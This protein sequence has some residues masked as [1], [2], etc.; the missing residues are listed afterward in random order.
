MRIS[1]VP[2]TALALLALSAAGAAPQI[3]SS[4]ANPLVGATSADLG[5]TGDSGAS[6]STGVTAPAGFCD[7]TGASGVTGATGSTCTT[8][9]T[10]STGVTGATGVTG[11]TGVA[12]ATG[13]TGVTGASAAISATGTTGST[14]TAGAGVPVVTA[15]T[16]QPIS[17]AALL[18]G[19][20]GTGRK[21]RKNAPAPSLFA[22][23]NPLAG[24]LPGSVF[25]PFVSAAI[26]SEVPQFFVENF[27]VPPFLLPIYQSAGAAY[28]VPWQVLAAINQV[29]TNYGQDLNVSS[30]GAEGWMQFLPSTWKGYGV[31]ATGSGSAD[32]YNAAD[33][34]FAAA[35]YLA[36][37]GASQ[38]LP[39]AIY[40]YNHSTA[41]VQSVLLR[42]E[43]LSGVP[44][45]LVSS[46]TELADGHF[47]IQLRYH[48]TYRPIEQTDPAQTGATS[49]SVARK[50][51][52]P[53]PS[54]V[55]AGVSGAKSRR[56]P[57]AEIFADSDAAVVAVQDGTIIGIG[58]DARLGRYIQLEDN[59]GNVYTYGGLASISQ[60]YPTPK[61]SQVGETAAVSAPTGL[62]TAPAPT[63]PATAGVQLNGVGESALAAATTGA[64]P[65][66]TGQPASSAPA[67]ATAPAPPAAP[68]L[69]VDLRAVL[70]ASTVSSAA[71]AALSASLESALVNRYYTPAFGLHRNQLDV[72]RL[73]VGSRVLAGTM[74]GR[75]GQ[76]R[77][78]R[79]PHL[80]FEIRPAGNDE[81][82]IDPQSFLD[83]WTQLETLELHRA[84]FTQPLF[85]P[86]VHA[87][88]AGGTLL[89]S[90][91]DLERIVLEDSHVTIALCERHAIADGSVDRRVLATIEFLAQSGL[92]P[93]VGSAECTAAGKQASSAAVL[94]SCDSVAITAI[95]GVPVAGNQGPGTPTDA[96]IN[97]LLTLTN[98]YAPASIASLEAVAG[99]TNTVVDPSDSGQIVVS[100]TPEHTP[101][102]LATTA[103][104]TGGFT[105]GDAR[106]TQLDD[107]LAQITEPRVPTVVST[108][109]L[110]SSPS[111]PASTS[112]PAG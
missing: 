30:A 91:I 82:L 87:T 92:D 74:L 62:A 106:W 41:Y 10:G 50:G 71:Q 13:V 73:T 54:A 68:A 80:V 42:A 104:F 3:G 78:G 55:S 23:A 63:A 72:K 105:L 21:S 9:A 45:T 15:I 2:K 69:M 27:D 75:L 11:T 56:L 31:D 109:A 67:S 108:A 107:H 97:A 61:P 96:A 40:S 28:G 81:A 85:G 51:D 7:V 111:S 64:L 20:S 83:A 49:A 70:T 65:E 77:N 43:L 95:N 24:V 60:Y 18:G 1:R 76:T 57:A 79:H 4:A 53:S 47:P 33:A 100:F 12:G 90:Q 52:A 93:T 112:S 37:A 86:D 84:D 102:V 8:G 22:E 110:A 103:A 5:A 98:G 44:T 17:G 26:G 46:V 34:I 48:A 16:A 58:H 6:S 101:L 99:A 88:D 29:E 36:A 66:A 25:D 32:P 35:R 89:M 14:T 19:A 94:A 39:A 38:N 59:F